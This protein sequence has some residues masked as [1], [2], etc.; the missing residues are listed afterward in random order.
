[1]HAIKQ[2]AVVGAVIA[3]MLAGGASEAAAAPTSA[4]ADCTLTMGNVGYSANML[5]VGGWLSGDCFGQVEVDLQ[6]SSSDAGP[7]TTV[8]STVT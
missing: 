3:S 7:L 4:A 6:Q 5:Y 2:V 8:E 1:M